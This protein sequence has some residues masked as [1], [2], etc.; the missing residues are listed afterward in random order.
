MFY[1]IS[2]IDKMDK[3]YQLKL[4]E[5]DWTEVKTLNPRTEFAKKKFSAIINGGVSDMGFDFDVP[6]DDTTVTGWQFI[7]VIEF[8]D[9]NK[10]GK[11]IYTWIVE[12]ASRF[13]DKK[14]AYVSVEC[15]GLFGLMKR[16]IYT[17]SWNRT[18]TQ[19]DDPGNIISDIV[20][21]FN[22]A[23]GGAWLSIGSVD[24]YW[25]NVTIT[26]DNRSCADSLK[27]VWETVQNWWYFYV[28][29]DGKVYFEQH[30]T[31]SSYNLKMW[32]E[33]SKMEATEKYE[34]VN[35]IRVLYS[36]W[37]RTSDSDATSI[38]TYWLSEITLSRTSLDS[39][40][41]TQLADQYINSH[42]DMIPEIKLE[43][44]NRTD[45]ED[46]RPWQKVTVYNSEYD[47]TNKQINKVVY[48]E[49]K[50]ILHLESFE[51]FGSAFL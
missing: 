6:I 49:K 43:V 16:A 12:R 34:I 48:E 40:T 1:L 8:D 37:W 21:A 22:T 14:G 5:N 32:P 35:K 7:K 20:S 19:T 36:W 51:S 2:I 24:T 17:S 41:A 3:F 44:V 46:M 33:I 28:A 30:P 47:V 10:S 23:Y 26:F 18:H 29:G 39:W 15:I 9:N 38:S 4:Y 11:T 27:D 31:S 13:L 25:S 42:K 45:M 50:V